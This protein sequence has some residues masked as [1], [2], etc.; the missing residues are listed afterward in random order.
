[1]AVFVTVIEDIDDKKLWR[2]GHLINNWARNMAREQTVFTKDVAPVNKRGSGGF[3][4]DNIRTRSQ[5]FPESRRIEYTVTSHAPYSLYVIHGTSGGTHPGRGYKLPGTYVGNGINSATSKWVGFSFDG[6]K[7][8]KSIEGQPAN[9]FL[10]EGLDICA[11]RHPSL[12][13]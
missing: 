3:L 9:D 8:V 11:I 6:R 1:M 13:R 7:L 4:R 5:R 12:R 2:D 10:T